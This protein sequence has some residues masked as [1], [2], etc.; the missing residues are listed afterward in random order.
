MEISPKAKAAGLIGAAAIAAS[1]FMPFEGLHLR[2]NLD[3]VAIREICWGHTKGV[4]INMVVPESTCIVYLG[5]DTKA[6]ETEV[7]H[8][9]DTTMTDKTKAAFISFVYNMG[10]VRF[11]ASTML[12]RLRAGDIIGACS[13]LATADIDANGVCHGYGCGWA[14]GV[15]LPGLTRRR[16]SEKALCLAGVQNVD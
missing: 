12:K 3:P 10:G 9:T 13:A 5:D 1:F 15:R 2:A 4:T 14:G 8:D 7:D 16:E 6:A 11:R